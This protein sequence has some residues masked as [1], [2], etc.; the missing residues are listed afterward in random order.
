MTVLTDTSDKD[1]ASTLGQSTLP[2][3]NGAGPTTNNDDTASNYVDANW[4][5][6][7]QQASF[8]YKTAP[9]VAMPPVP[10]TPTSSPSKNRS[11]RGHRST[12]TITKQVYGTRSQTDVKRHGGE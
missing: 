1:D 10:N 7:S 11:T 2:Y 3:S 8:H 5:C 6:E 4:D 12:K 9:A